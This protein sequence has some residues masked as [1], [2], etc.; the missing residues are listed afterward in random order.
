MIFKS[1]LHFK[2]NLGRENRQKKLIEDRTNLRNYND[3][4]IENKIN[5]NKVSN[6]EIELETKT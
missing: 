6:P 2:L 1:A 5:Q 4:K 3:I